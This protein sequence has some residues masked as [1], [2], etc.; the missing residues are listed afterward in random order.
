MAAPPPMPARGH[1]TA[2]SFD[3]S[4]PRELPR[5]FEDLEM[6]FT[7]SNITDAVAKKLQAARYVDIDTSA[8]WKDLDEY[9]PTHNWA[10]FKAAVYALYPGSDTDRMWSISDMDKLIGE[11]LRI[12]I[13][14][15][16]SLG[17][18][19]R[20]FL[21]ITKYLIGR[22]RLSGDEQ[23]RAF[24]RGFQ[25]SLLVRVGRRLELKFPNHY[26]DDPYPINDILDAAK[27]VL[28]GTSSVALPY[29]IPVATP[30]PP[31]ESVG[32]KKEDFTAYLDR[33]AQQLVQA[34]GNRSG[35]RNGGPPASGSAS[36]ASAIPRPLNEG[37]CNFCGQS[38]HFLSSCL[39]CEEY[40]NDGKCKRNAD[41]KIVLPTGAFCPRV[42]PGQ[43]LR[44]RINEWHRR[45]PGQI[46]VNSTMM[47]EVCEESPRSS[48]RSPQPV[49]TAESREP[50]SFHLSANQ[51]IS[52]LEHEI[53]TLRQRQRFDG[54]EI[55]KRP[56]RRPEVPTSS[57]ESAQ[58]AARAPKEKAN[59]PAP[60]KA[61]A[62][63]SLTQ[64]PEAPVVQSTQQPPKQTQPPVHPFAKVREPNYLPPHDRNFATAP[65]APHAPRDPAYQYT[66]RSR[67]LRSR[68]TCM[69]AG[70]RRR[71]SPS[72]LRNSSRWRLRFGTRFGMLL[73]PSEYLS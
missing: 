15:T 62:P 69:L 59:A 30:A 48:S 1:V 2:P 53:L 16:T 65:K 24:M 60:P 44:D 49:Y 64:T 23:S 18:Y 34:L 52:A 47:W 45:N 12:G 54:V 39:V 35:N 11:Q 55:L 25:P 58:A 7:T 20:A 51:R 33:F 9:G 43:W 32:I 57:G 73:R 50:Q 27:Y 61:P 8:L 17:V 4:N 40:I 63:T 3:V 29:D 14:D 10:A 66:P 67:I 72:R 38:G 5:Y 70:S 31:T 26:P 71:T 36:Q 6:L 21:G 13:T 28:H 42:I 37:L 46:A 56:Q 19:H 68:T 22:N 41:G